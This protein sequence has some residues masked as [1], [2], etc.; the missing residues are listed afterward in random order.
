VTIKWDEWDQKVVKA[1]HGDVYFFRKMYEG[2]HSELFPR[3]IDLM[4]KG[5]IYTNLI[6]GNRKGKNIRTPYITANVSKMIVNIPS[7]MVARSIGDIKSSI[8]STD[9]QNEAVNEDTNKI[10]DG[11]TGDAVN[12]KIENVQNEIIKQIVKNSN[13][14]FEHRSNVVQHQT[15]G[16]IVGVPWNDDNGLRI[17]FK[18]RD[19]YFPHEDGKGCDLA[20]ERTFDEEKYL[21][22]YR[23]RVDKGNLSATHTLYKLNGNRTEPVEDDKAKELLE[24]DSLVEIYQGRSRPFVVYWP[25]EKNM[26]NPLGV[27]ALQGIED[28]QDEVNWTLTRSGITFQRNGKPR[29]ALSKEI[30]MALREKSLEQFGVEG[31]FNHEDL[32][33]MTMDDQGNS[34][35]IIQV[36][37]TK[38]GDV[39]WVK[40]LM[41]IMMSETET[42]EKAAD[43]YFDGSSPAESGI[44]KFYDLI[45]SIEKAEDLQSEY[46]HFLK[47]LFE[48]CLWLANRD[49]PKVL[50]EE[51]EISTTNMLP[52]NR[53]E[54]VESNNKEFTDGTQS[55][56]TTVRRNNP[57]AS[58][59]WIVEE[60][61][62][63]KEESKVEN[64][65][66]QDGDE[67]NE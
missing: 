50:I 17:E 12:D 21:H 38:I 45:T 14:K 29:V 58:E 64:A 15:D 51:P 60:I 44:A 48:N 28:K 63:I 46:I 57:H 1:T 23:E 66:F 35:E 24:F 42:S 39:S 59:E 55:L 7:R 62:R 2:K 52:V 27:S 5:E 22:V 20:Y 56:E 40:E 13:L 26:S 43:F 16:G 54:I 3:A 8:E 6:N 36:D 53:K 30:M 41:K 4:E 65:A 18:M 31:K 32:E 9:E 19:V 37:I 33:V 11:P 67:E 34:M 47:Q 61:E 49:D 25:N 10:I